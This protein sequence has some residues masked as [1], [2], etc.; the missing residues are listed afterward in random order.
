[1]IHDR[2]PP[3]HRK[4]MTHVTGAQIQLA[5]REGADAAGQ[6]AAS[7]DHGLRTLLHEVIQSRVFTHK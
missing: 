7:S 2:I 3:T 1:V 5:G 6:R 4:T